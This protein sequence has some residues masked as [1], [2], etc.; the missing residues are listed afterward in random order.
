MDHKIARQHS[1]VPSPT[2]STAEYDDYNASHRNNN[3]GSEDKLLSKSGASKIIFGALDRQ[4]KKEYIISHDKSYREINKVNTK[5]INGIAPKK[6][7][8]NET[9]RTHKVSTFPKKRRTHFDPPPS[10]EPNISTTS[11]TQDHNNSRHNVPQD[12]LNHS[13]DEGTTHHV[14]NNDPHKAM[15]S[16]NPDIQN[17]FIGE[18]NNNIEFQI[19]QD[20]TQNKRLT[21]Q[22]ESESKNNNSNLDQSND[23]Q[24]RQSGPFVEYNQEK[25][26]TSN[27]EDDLQTRNRQL[28]LSSDHDYNSQQQH[29]NDPDDHYHRN[30]IE[31]LPEGVE[32]PPSVDSELLGERLLSMLLQVCEHISCFLNERFMILFHINCIYIV[33]FM[34]ETIVVTTA[35]KRDETVA[36]EIQYYIQISLNHV[37]HTFLNKNTFNQFHALIFLYPTIV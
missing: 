26:Q 8:I 13:N 28:E 21:H 4:E 27:L 10:I 23:T 35:L 7:I 20:H 11:Q 17:N 32:L 29:M 30:W 18:S 25:R 9:S 12:V 14:N 6:R 16:N 37:T 5:N 3:G 2:N 31:E 33:I 19:S 22:Y 15:T 1:N 36:T 24:G 34:L